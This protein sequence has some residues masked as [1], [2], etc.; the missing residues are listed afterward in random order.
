MVTTRHTA[1]RRRRKKKAVYTQDVLDA[2]ATS[3][4]RSNE[5]TRAESEDCWS[6]GTSTT[7]TSFDPD[8]FKHTNEEEDPLSFQEDAEEYIL[9]A[10]E[11]EEE[12][13]RAEAA[14]A[15]DAC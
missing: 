4:R 2:A 3:I 13:R 10:A 9:A 12:A 1:Q 5:G 15:E 14:Q 11:V 7:C 8:F 6:Q